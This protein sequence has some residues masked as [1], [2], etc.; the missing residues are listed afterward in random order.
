[1][2]NKDK[3]YGSFDENL[4]S[5]YGIYVYCD[6][7]IFEGQWKN[8]KKKG[9]MTSSSVMHMHHLNGMTDLM[10]GDGTMIQ[11]NGD[12]IEVSLSCISS[13]SYQSY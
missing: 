3:Y 1:M 12:Q 8:G 7:T 2:S 13:M 11:P 5:G 10:L 4:F 9:M 6:G